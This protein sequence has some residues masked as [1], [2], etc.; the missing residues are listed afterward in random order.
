MTRRHKDLTRSGCIAGLRME[1]DLA[2]KLADAARERSD[3]NVAE[4]A[5]YFIRTGTGLSHA[6]ANRREETLK[7]DKMVRGLRI[8][9]DLVAR[10]DR[11]TRH[12]R[13]DSRAGGARHLLRLALGINEV[14]SLKREVGFAAVAAARQG[15][16]DVFHG[17]ER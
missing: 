4:L 13:L 6:E 15:M 2:Q 9:E 8:E 16:R 7:P 1:T 3:G 11:F 17:A 14:E 10:L 12:A 5:R